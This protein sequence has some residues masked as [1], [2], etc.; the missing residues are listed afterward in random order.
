MNELIAYGGAGKRST[1]TSKKSGIYVTGAQREM[2]RMRPFFMLTN[3]KVMTETA[4]NAKKTNILAQTETPVALMWDYD[5]ASYKTVVDF[6][7]LL[8]GDS[9]PEGTKSTV[10]EALARRQATVEQTKNGYMKDLAD[11]LGGIMN[12]HDLLKIE[13]PKVNSRSKG[14]DKQLYNAKDYYELNPEVM[15]YVIKAFLVD[16]YIKL[17]TPKNSFQ[18]LVDKWVEQITE[19]LMS[20]RLQNP[21]VKMVGYADSR[22]EDNGNGKWEIINVLRSPSNLTVVGNPLNKEVV[23]YQKGAINYRTFEMRKYAFLEYMVAYCL[24]KFVKLKSNS[25]GLNGYLGLATT[26]IG[27]ITGYSTDI[28][29]ELTF[30]GQ[31]IYD[32]VIALIGAE[33]T[34]FNRY[35][36][37]TAE[38]MQEYF[39]L[40]FVLG[41]VTSKITAQK[42]PVTLKIQSGLPF[43]VVDHFKDISKA[44]FPDVGNTSSL[45][46]I[47]ANNMTANKLPIPYIV[48]EIGDPV[49]SPDKLAEVVAGKTLLDRANVTYEYEQW[50]GRQ[51]QQVHVK[52][53][54]VSQ[55]SIF[56]PTDTSEKWFIW[57]AETESYL[58]EVQYPFRYVMTWNFPVWQGT[59]VGDM[60]ETQRKLLLFL[61]LF[62][63][64]GDFMKDGYMVQQDQLIAEGLPYLVPVMTKRMEIVY[65]DREGRIVGMPSPQ[66]I[67]GKPMTNPPV[68][69]PIKTASPIV[70]VDQTSEHTDEVLRAQTQEQVE[71]ASASNNGQEHNTRA[72]AVNN[73]DAL[74]SESK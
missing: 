52:Y 63:S 31:S 57:T 9:E 60:T 47:M 7:D 59:E 34:T 73:N 39:D 55:D 62:T 26:L 4:E 24:S 50:T 44:P 41:F 35:P 6:M 67:G 3:G 2:T 38:S 17:V 33:M 27:E 37:R 23:Y 21:T 64:D 42:M 68:K 56:E 22:L 20:V 61:R 69:V 16:G 25:I 36:I 46:F 40:M 12:I 45:F 13:V 1:P 32:R 58:E 72:P 10:A 53:G 51:F 28:S 14:P 74:G 70:D 54:E 48:T 66:T 65:I 43:R 29:V 19:I 71:K 5:S 11:R 49:T 30:E 18:K 15:E 8:L